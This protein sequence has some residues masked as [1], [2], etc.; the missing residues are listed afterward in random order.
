[1]STLE[2]KVEDVHK[3][4]VAGQKS[5]NKILIGTAGTVIASVLGIIVTLLMMPK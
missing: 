5:T 2:E 4:I 3:D 1:L